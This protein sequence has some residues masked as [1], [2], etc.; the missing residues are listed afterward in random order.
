MVYILCRYD[1]RR[2]G[3][4]ELLIVWINRN[5]KNEKKLF[6]MGNLYEDFKYAVI[7]KKLNYF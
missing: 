6:C 5:M 1:V 4:I 3:F 2:A 7:Y